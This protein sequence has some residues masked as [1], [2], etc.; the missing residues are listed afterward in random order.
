MLVKKVQL[1]ATR[2]EKFAKISHETIE[3]KEKTDKNSEIL[4]DHSTNTEVR[5]RLRDEVWSIQ[6]HECPACVRAE[7]NST[8]CGCF[9][10]LFLKGCRMLTASSLTL[11][12][13]KQLLLYYDG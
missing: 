2:A 9:S 11:Q 8:T 1:H 10:F 6:R 4:E 7:R 3:S 5:N 12:L 13:S